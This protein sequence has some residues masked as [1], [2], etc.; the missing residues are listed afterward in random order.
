MNI[1][2]WL[3]TAREREETRQNIKDLAKGFVVL[4]VALSIIIFFI[5]FPMVL[6]WLI[7]LVVASIASIVL[8]NAF[9]PLKKED[10]E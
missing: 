10:N 8:W 6:L 7:I 5:I 2:D 1:N 3:P 9:A 4:C